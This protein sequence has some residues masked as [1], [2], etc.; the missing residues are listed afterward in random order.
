MLVSI[1]AA[2]HFKACSKGD[3]V[4]GYQDN[5]QSKCATPGSVLWN[6][7]K[8]HVPADILRCETPFLKPPPDNISK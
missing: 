8:G 7:H 3:K 6:F 2:G 1:H 4:I 5:W